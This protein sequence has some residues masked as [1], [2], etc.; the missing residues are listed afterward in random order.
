[1]A[2]P[3]TSVASLPV[4]QPIEGVELTRHSPAEGAGEGFAGALLSALREAGDAE[5]VSMEAGQKFADGDPTVGIQEAMIAS[6]KAQ[7]AVHYAVTLKNKA[8]EAYRELMNT[9]V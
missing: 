8:L 7:V 4:I 5:R 9:P 1:M 6:A 3:L 2:G